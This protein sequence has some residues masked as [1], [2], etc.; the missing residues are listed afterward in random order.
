MNE[1]RMYVEHLFEGRVLTAEMIELKEEIYGNLVARFEDYVASGMTAEEAL[2][3]TKES[4]TSI[5]DVLEGDRGEEPEAES[6]GAVASADATAGFPAD[7]GAQAAASAA[8]GATGAAVG[9]AAAEPAETVAMPAVAAS[10]AGTA[11]AG[12]AVSTADGTAGA[13]AEKKAP[14]VKVL[15]IAAAVIAVILVGTIVWNTVLEPSADQLEDTVEDVVEAQTDGDAGA[16]GNGAGDGT[17]AG[18]GAANGQGNSNGN[19]AGSDASSTPTFSDPED[20][21]EYEATM[22]VLGEIDGHDCT[23]LQAYVGDGA[24]RQ[25]F[26]ENLPLGS[27]VVTEGTEAA[28]PDAFTVYYSNVNDD[29]DGDAIDRALVYNAVAAFSTYPDLQYL[30]VTVREAHDDVGDMDV[31]SFSRGQLE[32]AFAN[33]SGDAV[34]QFNSSLFGS[35]TSWDVVR[36]QIDRHEFCEHQV[37]IAEIG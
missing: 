10:T 15:A 20:Q 18:N 37:E 11:A 22:T 34:I 7:S 19:G 25:A 17:G 3:K 29:I 6:D 8:V 9:A 30:N 24:P 12:S 5:E 23:Q 36:Q 28:G 27:Y 16:A 1:L 33:V 13:A 31:Y 32:S 2:R 4:I 21:R 14:W 35:E 26:F